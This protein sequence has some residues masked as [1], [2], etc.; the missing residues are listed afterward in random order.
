MPFPVGT[1]LFPDS[2]DTPY[3]TVSSA[4]HPLARIG[5]RLASAGAKP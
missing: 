2:D 1:T 4:F 3:G 5:L